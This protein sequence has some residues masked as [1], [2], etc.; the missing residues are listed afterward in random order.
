MHIPLSQIPALVGK[1]NSWG[2]FTAEKVTAGDFLGVYWGVYEEREYAELLRSPEYLLAS[3]MK[4]VN[5]FF[6]E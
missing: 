4:G 2:V 6:T 3:H 1:S 5:G